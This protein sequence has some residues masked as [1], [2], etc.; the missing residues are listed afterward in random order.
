MTVTLQFHS[1]IRAQGPQPHRCMRC[2]AVHII[3]GQ[4]RITL[5]SHGQ[6]VARLSPEYSYPEYAPYRPGPYRV[7]F[8]NGNWSKSYVNW[9]GEYFHN[10]PVRFS[11][12]SIMSWQGLA[13]DME[14]LKLMPYDHTSP[15]PEIGGNDDD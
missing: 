6:Q 5:K 9:N 10:G 4:N 11:D 7:R 3:D 12:G 1:W 14:H 2:G 15:L 8:N 13:G